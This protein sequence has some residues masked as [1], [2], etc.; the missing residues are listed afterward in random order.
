MCMTKKEIYAEQGIK[1]DQDYIYIDVNGKEYKTNT[2][3]KTGNSK[4]CGD[5]K[6][7][8]ENYCKTA[9]TFGIMH[10]CETFN[11]DQV[12]AAVTELM[13]MV[14]IDRVTGTCPMHCDNCYVDNGNYNFPSNVA[15]RMI[16]YILVRYFM[17]QVKRA[18][19]AQIIAD[20]ITQVRIH[21]AGD[22]FSTQYVDMWADIIK[23]FP[24]VKFW[25]YTKWEYAVNAFDQFDNAFITPSL[26]PAGLNFGTCT[27][28]LE[29]YRELTAAGYRVHICGC[30]TPYEK[31]CHACN[32]GC[33]AIGKGIDYVLF[34]KHSS[35]DY[36]AGKDDPL[37]YAAVCDIIARQDN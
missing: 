20:G 8:P 25:T 14:G 24:D 12:P 10:G 33:K 16:R 36:K 27:E 7:D 28:L 15:G 37:E 31:H 21:D 9:A 17:D 22:F 5:K 32:T 29:K 3:L 1:F 26:T 13:D 30:G 18:I 23:H 34:I 11:I 35:R 4:V 2:F 6:K 19:I